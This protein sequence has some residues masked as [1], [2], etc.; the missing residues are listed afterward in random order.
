MCRVPAGTS[1]V[2]GPGA[3]APGAPVVVLGREA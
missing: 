3:L 2:N 1:G